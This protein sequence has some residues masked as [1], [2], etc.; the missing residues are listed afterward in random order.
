MLMVFNWNKRKF[1]DFLLVYLCVHQAYVMFLSTVMHMHIK[2]M[3]TW[4]NWLFGF[5][6]TYRWWRRSPCVSQTI[7]MLLLVQYSGHCRPNLTKLPTEIS[8]MLVHVKVRIPLYRLHVGASRKQS[9]KLTVERV[10]AQSGALCLVELVDFGRLQEW[11]V[12]IKFMF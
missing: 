9:K 1:D 8:P 3:N 11:L 5:S 6:T 10:L 12:A 2:L 7:N 4:R